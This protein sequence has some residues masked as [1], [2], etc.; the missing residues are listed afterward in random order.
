[1]KRRTLK[2]WIEIYNKKTGDK[3][4]HDKRYKLFYFPER[5]FC[6]L[7]IDTEK[8]MVVVYQL[9][10]DILFWRHVM[11]IFAQSL[12]YHVCATY[13]ICPILPYLRLIRCRIVDKEYTPQGIRYY[14][15]EKYTGQKVM[16]SPANVV[17]LGGVQE[18]Y[19][20]WTI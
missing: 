1:M 5:G 11:E 17:S 13:C 3:F 9:C 18:Y 7:R 6:E 10:G 20:T 19:I 16:A 2:E 4:V 14:C 12:G 15:E 8:E